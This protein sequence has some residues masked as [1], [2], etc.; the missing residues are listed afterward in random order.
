MEC[1]CNSKTFTFEVQGTAPTQEGKNDN[2]CDEAVD[3]TVPQ[4]ESPMHK[5]ADTQW[6]VQ[7]LMDYTYILGE[8]MMYATEK[9]SVVE[10]NPLPM[11]S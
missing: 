1:Q 2:H 3:Q 4:S 7:A 6:E 5:D 10:K 9:H 11:P 8:K